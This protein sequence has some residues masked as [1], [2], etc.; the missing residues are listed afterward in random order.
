MNCVKVNG[1]IFVAGGFDN[2]TSNGSKKV[3]IYNPET[4]K[5]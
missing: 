3:A 4:E 5:I 1:G 2:L